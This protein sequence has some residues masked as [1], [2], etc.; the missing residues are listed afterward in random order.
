MVPLAHGNDGGGSIRIPAACCGLVGLKPARGRISVA[1]GMGDSPLVTD[2][3][4]TRTVADSAALLDVLAGPETGDASW[5]PP[6]G[7]AFADQA[8]AAPGRLR[9]AVTTASPLPGTTLDPLAADAVADA[10]AL[11]GDL[12]HD[13]VEIEAPWPGRGLQE[14]FGVMF[15][16]L[17]ALSMLDAARLVGREHPIESDAEPMNWAIWRRCEGIDAMRLEAAR[18]G[19]QALARRLIVTLDPYDALLTPALAER[20]LPL[21]TLDTY[22]PDPMGTFR[23]SGLFTPYTPIFNATGQPAIAVPLAHGSDGLPLSV[24]LA[25]RPAG[26][27]PLLALAAQL[28]AA[29]PWA[30]RRPL[31]P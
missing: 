18:V 30:D 16:A 4:L 26:E 10:A 22:G 7:R 8:A 12:G 21:G 3:V 11:L 28:E 25:G 9:I 13:V 2:G 20:P 29:R 17:I 5:A 1:P 6:P 15:S 31:E 19:M 27:G 14:S 23:R 24:Q